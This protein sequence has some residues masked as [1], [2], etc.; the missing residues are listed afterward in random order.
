MKPLNVLL[1]VYAFPPAG[2]VGVLRASS[3][4]RYLPLEGIRLDVLTTRNPS[5][6]GWDPSLMADIPRDVTI[7]RTITL[8]LPFQWKKALKKIITGARPPVAPDHAPT[9]V[10]SSSILKRAVVD[11]LL[12]DPQVLWLPILS[13]VAPSIVRERQIEVVIITGAPYSNYLLAE[14]LRRQFPKLPIVLDFRDEWL[15]TSFGQASFQFSRSNRARRFAERAET[16]AVASATKVVAV[17]RA[18][19]REI[20]GRYPGHEDEKF[21][22]IPNG[23]DA[24]RV[25]FSF[26]PTSPR[27]SGEVVV[28][29]LGTVYA[30][31]E[32]GPMVQA[33]HLLPE[34]FRSRLKIR[35]IGHIEEPSYRKALSSLGDMVELTGYM[36]QHEALAAMRDSDYALLI[37]HDRLNVSAKLYDYLGSGKPI[38]GCVHPE[39][40]ARLLLETLR[41]GW[42]A[43]SK[44]S[45]QIR[46]LFVQ[47][48]LRRDSLGKSFRPDYAAIMQFERQAIARR[49]A[50]MLH[51]M[52]IERRIAFP[53][54]G[55]DLVEAF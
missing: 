9:S 24:T 26:A 18:A 51:S 42:W 1:V 46:E 35:F 49:Y 33:L 11:L 23:F 4:A 36:P 52:F 21:E 14:K 29:Y 13:R 17:T 45:D 25:H 6:V 10:Q 41:G 40:E 12:P 7:H 50:A 55:A 48:I 22:Y 44:A 54:A 2:G 8:D 38:L 28:T 15:S 53:E 27:P 34:N 39:G 47:A 37:T 5:S 20:H 31:T 3:L 32:P 16:I 19:R 30:S 43:D